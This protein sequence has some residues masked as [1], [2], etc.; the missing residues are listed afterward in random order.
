MIED[1]KVRK[2]FSNS[3]FEILIHFALSIL[4]EH[5]I[6][7]L[8]IRYDYAFIISNGHDD[9]PLQAKRGYTFLQSYSLSSLSHRYQ[10]TNFFRFTIDKA[11]NRCRVN[12]IYLV[13]DSN[14]FMLSHA[15][16]NYYFILHFSA[17]K[18]SFRKLM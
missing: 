14:L 15:K 17:N 11:P 12:Y 6:F 7:F 5:N 1:L 2:L 10:F 18:F 8:I 9:S 3:L 13:Y 16:G 4:P